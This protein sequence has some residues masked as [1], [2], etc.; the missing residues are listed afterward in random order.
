MRLLRLT[1]VALCLAACVRGATAETITLVSPAGPLPSVVVGPSEADGDAAADLCV[2]LSQVSGRAIVVTDT[3]AAEGVIIHVGA[4]AFVQAH[5]PAIDGLFA[6]GYVMQVVAFEGRDHLVLAGKRHLSSQWAVEQ[7]LKEFCGVRWLFPD[8]VY[9][10]VVPSR[11]TITVEST[12]AQAYEP[13]YLHRDNGAMNLFTADRKYLRLGPHRYT[14]GQHAVQYMFTEPDFQDHPEWFAWFNGKRQWWLVGNGWQICTANTGTVAHAVAYVLDYFARNPDH[15]VVSIGQNDGSGWCEDPLCTA[16]VN[17]FDPPYTISE[18]WFDW[19][20][21]VAREVAKTYPHKWVE[22]MAYS[23]TASPPRFPLEPNVAVTKTFV[24]AS[25]LQLAE[26]WTN[27]CRSVNLYSYM[28]GGHFF[29]FRHY[30]HA[31]RDFLKWGHDTLGSLAH[32]YECAGDWTFDGPKYHYLQALQWDVNADVDAVMDD[33]CQNSYGVAAVPMRAFWDRLE[34][35]YERRPPVFLGE[36]NR[37]LLFYQW[38]SWANYSYVQ[39][40]DEFQ[41]YTQ[42]DV[43]VL[44]QCVSNATLAAAADAEAVQFRVARLAE[45]WAY[46]RTLLLT[47]LRY[48][49]NPPATGVDSAPA[50]DAALQLAREI[51][52]LRAERDDAR[53]RLKSY[54][55]INPRMNRTY[56]WELGTGLTIFSHELGLLDT[57]CDSITAYI[58]DASG[59]EAATAYWRQI[60]PSDALYESARTQL[61][62]LSHSELPQLLRNGDFETGNLSG[63]DVSGPS[64]D[65]TTSPVH[66]G[67]YAARTDGDGPDVLSQRVA[68]RPGDRYRLTAWARYLTAPPSWAIPLEALFEFYAADARIQWEPTRCVLR[69]KDPADGWVQLISTVTVPSWADSAIL[70]LTKAAAATTLWDDVTLER[71]LEGPWVSGGY[72]VDPFDG[73]AVD[74]RRWDRPMN[75]R[76]T[77]WPRVDEGWLVNDSSAMD[78]LVSL[79]SFNDLFSY[80]GRHRYRLRFHASTLSGIPDE[81]TIFCFG[82]MAGPERISTGITGMFWYHYFSSAPLPNAFLSAFHYQNATLTLQESWGLGALTHPCT[83]AWYSVLFDPT[84]VT[85]YASSEGYDESPAALVAEYE[86]GITDLT[87]QGAVHLKLAEGRYRLDEIS[88]V[89]EPVAVTLFETGFEEE[90]GYQLGPLV[91]GHLG[92]PGN[93]QG[94]YGEYYYS[95]SYGT[96]AAVVTNDASHGGDMSVRVPLEDYFYDY[97]RHAIARK[98]NGTLVVEWWQMLGAVDTGNLNNCNNLFVGCFDRDGV[99]P[100]DPTWMYGGVGGQ[101]AGHTEYGTSVDAGTPD[102]YWVSSGHAEDYPNDQVECLENGVAGPGAWTGFRSV[103]NLDAGRFDLYVDTGSGWTQKVADAELWYREAGA[104]NLVDN[105]WFSQLCGGNYFNNPN[106]ASYIDDVKITWLPRGTILAL[107]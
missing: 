87:A 103:I 11:P 6:D 45:A 16:F 22:A 82:I 18:R 40:N 13:D 99:K 28:Y 44:D 34:A 83:Q 15:P 10:E 17:S 107:K 105:F 32:V 48:Y 101:F 56:Y 31:A 58:R 47:K 14:Y 8:P 23:D 26:D 27:V 93:Q 64:V 38:V 37:R 74:S 97:Y 75:A 98:H 86:H 12:L 35:V 61:Y 33:F 104:S 79:A 36:A 89:H 78:A 19:V 57:L 73:D 46:A 54:R 81:A 69:T 51:A 9:G 92:A 1:G 50:R 30:P 53:C 3:P 29:G 2:Y 84:T 60:P 85:V 39:P 67:V 24:M 76:G 77:L 20:N 4:D 25:E 52:D 80:R 91:T 96:C 65:V 59:D 68:V 21:Q 100:G 95:R 71:I 41:E 70:R 43:D 102:S 63:W 5:V 72:L 62:R 55:D 42:E 7:F 66:G 94:W 88:L 90:E 106:T 49:D